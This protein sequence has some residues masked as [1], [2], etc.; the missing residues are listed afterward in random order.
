MDV[1]K[2]YKNPEE[3]LSGLLFDGMTIMSGGFGVLACLK[4]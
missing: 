4:I 1:E 3:A 2:V